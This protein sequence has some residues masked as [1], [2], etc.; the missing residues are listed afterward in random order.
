MDVLAWLWESFH[1]VYIYE[2]IMFYSLNIYIIFSNYTC[3]KARKNLKTYLE[4]KKK[5]TF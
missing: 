4:N 3:N 1:S 2:T 5:N